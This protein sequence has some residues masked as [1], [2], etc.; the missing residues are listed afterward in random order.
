[1]A[2]LNRK[3]RPKGTRNRKSIVREFNQRAAVVAVSTGLASD[4]LTRL[5][6]LQVMLALM[7]GSIAAGELDAGGHW[8]KE[9]APYMHARIAA[10]P[11]D[12]PIPPEL[13]PDPEYAGEQTTPEDDRSLGDEPPPPGPIIW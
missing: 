4:K 12:T 9:A 2:G 6:P 11:A 13:L 5:T 10:V 3:G 8:A 7:H 1:M